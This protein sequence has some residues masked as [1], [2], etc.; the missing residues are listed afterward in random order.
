M[1]NE[2]ASA[3][4]KAGVVGAGGAMFPTHVKAASK[5]EIVIANGAE[6]EPLLASDRVVMEN[7]A[8][9]VVR[10]LDLMQAATGAKKGVV[11][12]KAKNEI[13]LEAMRSAV[14]GYKDKEVFPLDDVYPAGDEHCLTFEVIGRTVPPGGIPIQAG[15]VVNNVATLLQVADAVKR[16]GR[17]LAGGRRPLGPPANPTRPDPGGGP[18]S[19]PPL[20]GSFLPSRAATTKPAPPQVYTVGSPL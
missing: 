8:H 14:S 7:F 11:A 4:E 15:V 6:C 20:W 18:A 5:A 19:R 16:G 13:A 1:L 10:G 17:I 9:E 12:V 3:I 2:I